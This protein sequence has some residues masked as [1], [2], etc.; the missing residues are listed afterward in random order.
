MK[1]G[2]K[3]KYNILKRVDRGQIITGHVKYHKKLK[4]KQKSESKI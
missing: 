1:G 3:D 4:S 2:R